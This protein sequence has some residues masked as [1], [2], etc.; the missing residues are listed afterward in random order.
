[1]ATMQ[2]LRN[3]LVF[4]RTLNPLPESFSIFMRVLYRDDVTPAEYEPRHFTQMPDG[5][6]RLLFVT[7]PLR[8]RLGK[9]TTN[10]HAIEL[11]LASSADGVALAPGELRND[12]LV[13][14]RTYDSDRDVEMDLGCSPVH[15][16]PEPEPSSSIETIASIGNSQEALPLPLP[17]PPS[18]S[19]VQRQP[20]PVAVAIKPKVKRCSKAIGRCPDKLW[21]RALELLRFNLGRVFDSDL[22]YGLDISKADAR[23][24]MA[25]LVESGC[26]G[27]TRRTNTEMIQKLLDPT[28]S[29]QSRRIC[30]RPLRD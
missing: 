26:V 30:R 10:H 24:V 23:R 2:M 14:A 5:I 13:V 17:P 28:T 3:I 8:V 12:L 25:R 1:M 20:S 16:T 19:P 6:D 29:T 7:T 21:W 27:R 4:G 22:E 18:P 15:N 11:T 9:V